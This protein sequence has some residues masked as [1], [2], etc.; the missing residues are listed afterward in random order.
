MSSAMQPLSGTAALDPQVA[1]T[2]AGDFHSILF[3]GA[4]P[5]PARR[6]PA[7]RT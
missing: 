5:W 6:R 1:D 7:S 2:Q 4:R 3:P